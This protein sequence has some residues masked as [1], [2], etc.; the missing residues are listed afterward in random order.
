[1]KTYVLGLLC[2]ASLAVGKYNIPSNCQKH[3]TCRGGRA[4]DCS[5]EH[6][7]S[8]SWVSSNLPQNSDICQLTVPTSGSC[9]NGWCERPITKV[10]GIYYYDECYVLCCS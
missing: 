3:V 8:C 9:S 2:L 1:M 4:L 5:T 6:K 10:R 7:A